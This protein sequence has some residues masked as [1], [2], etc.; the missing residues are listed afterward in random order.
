M[1]NLLIGTSKML[2]LDDSQ[3]R[4]NFLCG[5]KHDVRGG[6]HD[7]RFRWEPHTCKNEVYTVTHVYTAAQA[8]QQIRESDFDIIS[9]DY[10]L[11]VIDPA[12]NNGLV[13][14]Q[15]LAADFPKERIPYT[16]V[17]I[18]SWNRENREV[19]YKLL[20]NQGFNC[21]LSHFFVA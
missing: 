18:H 21:Y 13:V 1:T 9:L 20:C 10:D 2:F 6:K 16:A 8:I 4:H 12:V 19:M 14:A 17:F 5:K 11:T 3:T 7:G 15:Y